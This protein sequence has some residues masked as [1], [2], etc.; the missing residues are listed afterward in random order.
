LFR[1]GPVHVEEPR[2]GGASASGQADFASEAGRYLS[3]IL[4]TWGWY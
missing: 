2:P 3:Q 4:A 1:A